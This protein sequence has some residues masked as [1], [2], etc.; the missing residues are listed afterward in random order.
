MLRP[1]IARGPRPVVFVNRGFWRAIPCSPVTTFNFHTAP[2][3]ESEIRTMSVDPSSV[4][5]PLSAKAPGI[6]VIIFTAGVLGFKSIDQMVKDPGVAWNVAV[7]QFPTTII[8]MSG[9]VSI[10]PDRLVPFGNW[11]RNYGWEALGLS[12]YITG[13]FTTI[14]RRL[15][16][17][18]TATFSILVWFLNW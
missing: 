15:P 3:T 10:I 7:D 12:W 6:G 9:A 17:G 13:S 18:R 11:W 14:S 16:F 1:L 8:K 5:T 2:R 4:V